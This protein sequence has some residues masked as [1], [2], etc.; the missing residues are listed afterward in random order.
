MDEEL[1]SQCSHNIADECSSV[2]RRIDE[3]SDFLEVCLE[4]DDTDGYETVASRDVPTQGCSD[5]RRP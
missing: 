5:A 2:C 1:C 3:D 4:P